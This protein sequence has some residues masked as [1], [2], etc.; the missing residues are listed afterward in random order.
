MI[1]FITW[2][3]KWLLRE[4]SRQWQPSKWRESLIE[5]QLSIMIHKWKWTMDRASEPG[6]WSIW[7]TLNPDASIAGANSRW[8][9]IE[10][11]V[12][13]I[14]RPLI[15]QSQL[16]KH[17]HW[18]VPINPALSLVNLEISTPLEVLPRQFTVAV[19]SRQ[20]SGR[21]QWSRANTARRPYTA[22]SR[23]LKVHGILWHNMSVKTS[24]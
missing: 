5:D 7:D 24:F 15:G 14:S 1:P 16:M 2:N 6:E 13:I 20:G 4:S 11:F 22:Q 19:D 8:R 3:V 10:M 21:V 17:F 12:S 18:A 23:C 9:I